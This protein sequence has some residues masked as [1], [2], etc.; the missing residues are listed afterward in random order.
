METT[1]E[2]AHLIYDNYCMQV[3]GKAFNGDPLP[4]SAEFF[5]DKSKEKQANAWRSAAAAAKTYFEVHPPKIN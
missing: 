2:V 5:S 3:G 1:E 4:G